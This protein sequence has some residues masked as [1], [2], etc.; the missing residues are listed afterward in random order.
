MPY[1]PGKQAWNS[2]FNGLTSDDTSDERPLV[3]MDLD[4]S[5]DVHEDPVYDVRP[6]D[7]VAQVEDVGLVSKQVQQSSWKF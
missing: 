2:E 6:T 1:F 4:V 7:D 3:E 5:N